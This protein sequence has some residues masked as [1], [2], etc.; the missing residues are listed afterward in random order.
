[1]NATHGTHSTR[2]LQRQLPTD[3]V[4]MQFFAK[5]KNN[6]KTAV[7]VGDP[8][9][10]FATILGQD[11][12]II[13]K[14]KICRYFEEQNLKQQRAVARG[15]S[16]LRARWEHLRQHHLSS[17]RF[18]RETANVAA[19]VEAHRNVHACSTLPRR[20]RDPDLAFARARSRRK[21]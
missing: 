2:K 21:I 19:R 6:I 4:P 11:L 17:S 1:M 12:T 5:K 7:F 13:H 3:Q 8:S 14:Q 20:M 18:R 16:P 9:N 10:V 15:E